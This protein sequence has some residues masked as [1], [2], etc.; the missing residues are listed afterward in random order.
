M[1]GLEDEQEFQQDLKVAAVNCKEGNGQLKFDFLKHFLTRCEHKGKN[2]FVDKRKEYVSQ[3]RQALQAGDDAAYSKCVVGMIQDEEK[4]MNE[5]IGAALK[6]LNLDMQAFGMAMMM[7]QQDP[8]KGKQIMEIQQ[9][10]L[11]IPEE[12]ILDE[13]TCLKVFA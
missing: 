4:N 9:Q 11:D 5:I 10:V 13:G 7:S 6:S 3:R 8:Q 12:E 2:M 1:W